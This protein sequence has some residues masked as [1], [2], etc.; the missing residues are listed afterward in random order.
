MV[1]FLA[2]NC[3]EFDWDRRVYWLFYVYFGVLNDRNVT[4]YGN[5]G[6]FGLIFGWDRPFDIVGL[7]TETKNFCDV[8]Y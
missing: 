4:S 8:Y 6:L 2:F 3:L 5:G 7:S 1:F